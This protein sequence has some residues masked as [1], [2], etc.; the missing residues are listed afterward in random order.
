MNKVIDYIA[1]KKL[2][3][4]YLHRTSVAEEAYLYLGNLNLIDGNMVTSNQ[5]FKV[6]QAKLNTA[7]VDINTFNPFLSPSLPYQ[8]RYIFRDK[9]AATSN[10]TIGSWIAL[11]EQM[12]NE[13][14]ECIFTTLENKTHGT[15]K[16]A[17][18]HGVHIKDG[19]F[20]PFHAKA[21]HLLKPSHWMPIPNLP[22][23]APHLPESE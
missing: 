7:W 17:I 20:R 23:P 4:V 5:V 6:L 3:G 1:V 9:Q 12:P 18:I 14:E 22:S 15:N 13:M 2:D 10:N 21:T 11:N 8:T 16:A 19:L